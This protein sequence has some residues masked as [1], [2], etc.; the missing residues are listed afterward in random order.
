MFLTHGRSI[1]HA[2]SL[3]NL[4]AERLRALI[5]LFRQHLRH[6]CGSLLV[7]DPC[8]LAGASLRPKGKTGATREC[9]IQHPRVPHYYRARRQR[10][11]ILQNQAF[12][13]TTPE[14]NDEGTLA[15]KQ[16]PGSHLLSQRRAHDECNRIAESGC[17]S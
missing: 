5:S 7:P 8:F 12:A 11:H 15:R 4:D 13:S 14:V 1:S 6:R 2:H 3:A 9:A 10:H 16:R 17:G